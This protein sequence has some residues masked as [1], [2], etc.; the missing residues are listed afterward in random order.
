MLR[1]NIS[2]NNLSIIDGF[3]LGGDIQRIAP[4]LDVRNETRFLGLLMMD[5]EKSFDSTDWSLKFYCLQYN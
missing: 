1:K 2:T 3:L 5:F 4:L